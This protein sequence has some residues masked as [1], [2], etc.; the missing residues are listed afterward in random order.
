MSIA[1]THTVLLQVHLL[2]DKID[3]DVLVGLMP[4]SNIRAYDIQVRTYERLFL[5]AHVQHTQS[6]VEELIINTRW[7]VCCTSVQTEAST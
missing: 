7:S 1:G 6:C 5:H 3:V 4:M 2:D